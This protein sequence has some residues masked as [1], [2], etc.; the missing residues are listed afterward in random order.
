MLSAGLQAK[1]LL[2]AFGLVSTDHGPS[3]AFKNCLLSSFLAKRMILGTVGFN[4]GDLDP[5]A[6]MIDQCGNLILR[7]L[8]EINYSQLWCLS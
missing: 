5:L 4:T 7:K 1:A 3:P 8:I 2:G 6:T